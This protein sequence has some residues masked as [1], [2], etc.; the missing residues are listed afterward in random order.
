MQHGKISEGRKICKGDAK[1]E[2]AFA[3]VE[4]NLKN[5]PAAGRHIIDGKEM[6]VDVNVYQTQPL[7]AGLFENHQVYIDVQCMVK[8]SEL[9]YY[10]PRQGLKLAK[11]YNPER[12]AE[13][14]AQP[15]PLSSPSRTLAEGEFMI[16]EPGEAHLPGRQLGG[17][18][19]DVIKFVVKVKK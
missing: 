2:R 3:W 12:D 7:A 11:E 1:L 17:K 8:G 18:A 5:V 6:F 15:E 4:A 10:Q 16:F 19:E 9:A 13:F 14:Y